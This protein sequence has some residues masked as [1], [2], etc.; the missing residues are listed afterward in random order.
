MSGVGG[1]LA[2]RVAGQVVRNCEFASAITQ[3]QLSKVKIVKGV[4]NT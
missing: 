4:I 2:Q 3:D 1:R